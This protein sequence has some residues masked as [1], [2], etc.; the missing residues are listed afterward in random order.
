M[1]GTNIPVDDV[2][3]VDLF[4][5]CD[6]LYEIAHTL[7]FSDGVFRPHSG[8]DFLFKAV[9]TLYIFIG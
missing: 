7:F 5:S 6:N 4:D 3:V 2:D 8:K 9:L 1:T